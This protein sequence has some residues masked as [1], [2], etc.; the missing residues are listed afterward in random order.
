M[1]ISLG[2]YW[3]FD[4]SLIAN[5]KS[6]YKVRHEATN[7]AWSVFRS[8]VRGNSLNEIKVACGQPTLKIGLIAVSPK[9]GR[10]QFQRR[11]DVRYAT[12]VAPMIYNNAG[13]G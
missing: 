2:S 7:A 12:E 3:I 11:I 5:N 13:K 9:A 8:R 10:C 1:S 4:I 6:G